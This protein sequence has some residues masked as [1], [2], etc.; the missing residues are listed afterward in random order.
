MVTVGQLLRERHG[1]DRVSL[2]GFARHRGTVLAAA[3]WGQPEAV[4]QLPVARQGSH[5]DLLHRALG[6][7]AV[8]PSGE[9]RAA[10]WLT[11]P[12][13]HHVVG[14]IYDP[15]RELTQLRTDPDGGSL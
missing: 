14:V 5:E 7:R 12:L 6:R 8:L 3:G 10:S 1:P 4:L 11:T 9:H 15:S 2:V 13:G